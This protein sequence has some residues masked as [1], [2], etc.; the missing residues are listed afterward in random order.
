MKDLK[1]NDKDNNKNKNK[2]KNIDRSQYED[3]LF[4]VFIKN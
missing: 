1:N 2:N 4:L 3:V